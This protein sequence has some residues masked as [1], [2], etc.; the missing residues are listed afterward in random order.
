MSMNPI[1][2]DYERLRSDL[3]QLFQDAGYVHHELEAFFE[4]AV[5]LH[6]K[7]APRG[8]AADTMSTKLRD[9]LRE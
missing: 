4:E 9:A 1:K 8:R 6:K 3:Q 7:T 5:K 2:P